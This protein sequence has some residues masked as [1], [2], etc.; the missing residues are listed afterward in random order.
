MS[1]HLAIATVTA[2][3]Q[4]L[5]QQSVQNSV[6]G[7]RVVSARPEAQGGH[8]PETGICLYLYHLRR[9]DAYGN[10]DTPGRQRRAKLPAATNWPSIS[11]TYCRFTAMK[12]P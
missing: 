4:R 1:N 12:A 11:I 10:A 8:I 5:L 3:L 2:T 9:N 6:E 7:A